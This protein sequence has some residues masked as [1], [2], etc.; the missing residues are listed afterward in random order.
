MLNQS[1]LRF[2]G[3]RR[4]GKEAGIQP[5]TQEYWN[6]NARAFAVHHNSTLAIPVKERNRVST[7]AISPAL[8][9]WMWLATVQHEILR[10]LN[11]TCAI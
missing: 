11:K 5:L 10:G 4:S 8:D 3:D 6:E 9:R 2:R 1:A 7:G